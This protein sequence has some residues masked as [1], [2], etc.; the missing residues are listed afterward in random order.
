MSSLDLTCKHTQ[1]T[2]NADASPT[3]TPPPPPPP[4]LHPPRAY[5]PD[6]GGGAPATE[7]VAAENKGDSKA[8]EAHPTKKRKRVRKVLR[9]AVC[10]RGE[11]L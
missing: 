7:V 11:C 3:P 5:V 2:A 1:Q 9:V 10:V 6:G 4:P 8:E